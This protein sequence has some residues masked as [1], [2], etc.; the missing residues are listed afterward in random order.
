[1]RFVFHVFGQRSKTTVLNEYIMLRRLK[2]NGI[3][4]FVARVT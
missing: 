3:P 1:M 2:Y 4:L